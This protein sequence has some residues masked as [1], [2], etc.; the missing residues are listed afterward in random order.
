MES[1]IVSWEMTNCM[2][3]VGVRF[4]FF[5]SMSLLGI[6]VYLVIGMFEM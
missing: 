2:M 5:L 4:F 3:L 1:P 6:V